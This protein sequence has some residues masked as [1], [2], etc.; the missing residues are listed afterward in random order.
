[1]CQSMSEDLICLVFDPGLGV[2]MENSDILTLI[3]SPEQLQ[4][5]VREALRM[6][7]RA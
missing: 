6:L 4:T 5:K 1:M 3:E 7:E 2:R